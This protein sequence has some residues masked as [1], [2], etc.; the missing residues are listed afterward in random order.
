[1]I[2]LYRVLA[3]I[4]LPFALLFSLLAVI[5]L[6]VALANPALFIGVFMLA[7][8]CIYYFCTFRFLH[9][10]ILQKRIQKH[11]LRDWIK[12]NAYVAMPFGVV[13]FM[14][15]TT[16]ITKPSLLNESIGQMMEMQQQMGFPVYQNANL[17]A[18]L[19]GLLYVMLVFSVILLVHITLSFL[20]LKKYQIIFESP[21]E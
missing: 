2:G 9:A 10:G 20:L 3:Y 8:F 1:M 21:V 6:F 17:S 4:M 19:M 15:S 11:K 12:V 16:I 5:T 18:M 14:Q 13:N 7:A